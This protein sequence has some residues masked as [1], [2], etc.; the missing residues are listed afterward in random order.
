MRY[1]LATQ[2]YLDDKLLEPGTVIGDGTPFAFRDAKGRPAIPSENMVPL[3]KET[4]VQY[5][6]R[7]INKV[8]LLKEE[9]DDRLKPKVYSGDLMKAIP[10]QG[11]GSVVKAEP[12]ARLVVDPT[13]A[14]LPITPQRPGG[15][16]IYESKPG[17]A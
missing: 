11:T 15:P 1:Q 13:K 10:L 2:H 7:E 8:K 4:E 17:D 12:I 5:R 9:A 16:D 14:G 3:D 6:D